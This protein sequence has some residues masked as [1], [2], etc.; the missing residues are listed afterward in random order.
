[1]C[2]RFSQLAFAD[3]S[4]PWVRIQSVGA[5]PKYYTTLPVQETAAAAFYA[6]LLNQTLG[7]QN[8]LSPL[9]QVTV[10]G[11]QQRMVDMSVGAMVASMT[12]F[13]DLYPNY[14]TG[15]LPS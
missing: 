12:V 13:L 2:Y 3:P 6:A 15:L 10:P 7:W 8:L 4:G 9:I 14:G 5:P 1:M 11:D